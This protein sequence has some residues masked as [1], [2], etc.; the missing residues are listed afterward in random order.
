MNNRLN[1]EVFILAVRKLCIVFMVFGIVLGAVS[2]EVM[3]AVETAYLYNLS[4]FSGTVPY[5][6]ARVFVDKERNEIYV[7]YQNSISVFN[8][9]G[10]EIYRFGDDT[11]LGRIA[12]AAVDRE[13]NIL[14]LTYTESGYEIIRCNFRGDPIGKLEIKN[15]PVEFSGFSPDRMI[16]RD[17]YLYLASLNRKKVVVA[18]SDGKF[19]A[20]Y[21]IGSLL[22]GLSEFEK[23]DIK[24]GGFS[25]DRDG[26][27]LFTL[28]TLFKAFRLSPDRKMTAFGK[29]GS[30]PGLFGVV[31]GIISDDRGNYLVADKL[32]SIV[33][34][35]DSEYRFLTQFGFRGVK[36]GNLIRPQDLS[37]DSR[38]RVYV[39][40]AAKRGISV[41]KLTYE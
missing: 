26:N 1:I 41:F 39:T 24:M 16:Y 14:M 15:L 32:K 10:M 17:G 4:N 40:Q 20:G 2:A 25:V 28:P 35:F 31:S 8:A 27:I 36:P 6:W 13:G 9:S 34:V 37:I 21:D 22:E 38:N 29:P 12:D 11:D 3:A 23:K 5:S 18:T 30:A 33:M 19:E 7:L